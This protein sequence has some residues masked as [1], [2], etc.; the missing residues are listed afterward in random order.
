ML[1][2]LSHWAWR[3]LLPLAAGHALSMALVAGAVVR[4]MAVNRTVMLL[5]AGALLGI[6]AVAHASRYGVNLRRHTGRLGLALGSFMMATAH[7]AGL[8]LV[9]ALAP[10]CT[11]G[12]VSASSGFVLA[13]GPMSVHAAAMPVAIGLISCA[14]SRAWSAINARRR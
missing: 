7:G 9:P 11:S 2:G 8:M 12:T 14:A 6:L 13:L 5:V 1:R 4:G 10:L 3:T